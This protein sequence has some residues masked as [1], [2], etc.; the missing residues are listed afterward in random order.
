MARHKSLPQFELFVLQALVR[1]GGRAF[2]TEIQEEIRDRAR[3]GT[4]LGAVYATLGRLEERGWVAHAV[5][6]PRPIQGGK[7]RK[8]FAITKAGVAALTDALEQLRRMVED[9]AWIPAPR[10]S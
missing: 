6:D 8:Y 10:R 1:R 3:R 9:S 4:S 7:S 5:T 2:S